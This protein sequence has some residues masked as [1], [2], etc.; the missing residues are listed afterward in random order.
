MLDGFRNRSPLR[1]GASLLAWMVLAASPALAGPTLGF[2]EEWTGTSLQNWGG[3]SQYQ[4]P[5]TGGYLGVGDGYLKMYTI[6]NG[7]LGVFN[8]TQAD[9]IGNW[10]AAGIKYI[11]VWLNDVDTKDP[12]EIHFSIGIQG[13]NYWQYNI[14]FLPLNNQWSEFVADLTNSANWTQI[15]G[16]GTFDSALQNVGAVHFRHDLAPYV[17][18]PDLV[19][20]DVGID[21]FQLTDNVLDVPGTPTVSRPVELRAPFPNPS[22]GP[23]ALSFQAYEPGRVDLEVLDITGRS[24]RHASVEAS[25]GPRVWLWDGLDD[26]GHVLAPGAY[27]VRAVGAGG[28]TSRPLIRVR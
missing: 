9:Y 11:R 8:N 16:P 18:F 3:G 4:N 19:K 17:Q 7:R 25:A 10:Q 28:G 6:T 15:F 1:L 26:R 14:G 21:H 12:V 20:A 2:I 5:G 22:R 27:R 24:L 23:V 13:V